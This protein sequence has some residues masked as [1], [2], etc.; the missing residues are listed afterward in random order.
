MKKIF[1]NI[2]FLL[3]FTLTF[4]QWTKISSIPSKSIVALVVH[5]SSIYAASDSNIIY[6]SVD[7][8][9]WSAT[10]VSNVPVQLTSLAFYNNEIYVGTSDVSVFNSADNGVTWHNK[11]LS[12]IP[13]S[14]FA[15]NNNI[16]FAATFGD[17]VY[18]LNTTTKTWLPFT[19]SLPTYSYNVQNIISAPN[20]LIIG[21]GSN[22]TF[23]RYDFA[24][25]QWN[26]EYY[27]GT[28]KPGLQINRMINNASTIFAVNGNKI[29]RSNN[30]GIG[31]ADDHR[32]THNGADR[33]IY[34]GSANN[35]T[36]TNEV[37]RGTWIQQRK[38][39]A[40][41]GESWATDEEFFPRGYS[42]DIVEFNDK[43]FLAKDDGL[44][45]KT[46][47]TGP[48]PV[49][50]LSV[51]SKC[52]TGKVLLTWKTAQEQNSSYFNVEKSIDSIHW[53]VI[54]NLSAVGNS[55]IERS[56]YFADKSL[57]QNNY[58]RIAEYDADAK[59]QYSSVV[60]TSCSISDVIRVWPNPTPGKIIIDIVTQSRSR[61]LIKLIDTKGSTVKMQQEDL[62]QGRNQVMVDVTS[63]TNGI[64]Y[65]YAEWNNGQM[66]KSMEVV[67]Q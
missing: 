36:L 27:Y 57:A 31:W 62:S 9:N 61:V 14:R 32:G 67:K 26:E 48:L 34:S 23:Y 5:N 19:N 6:K 60:Q 35:Y 16:L 10:S 42:F 7:G 30:S 45:F 43:L 15:V 29:I 25:N 65:L 58:Y 28:L 55:S 3:A 1:L 21:A 18:N 51:N 13:S 33:N 52:E 54:G 50:F 11:A 44:Y 37:P 47:A 63:L 49:T 22:G 38:K 46:I 59:V 4:A 8:F 12:T 66:K 53:A 17:G 20:F 39:N 64:Y 40:D 41:V 2:F 56:Y 24:A